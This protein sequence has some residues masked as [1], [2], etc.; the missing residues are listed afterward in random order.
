MRSLK[1]G[2]RT[3]TASI[4]LPLSNGLFMMTRNQSWSGGG[5]SLW[6][7]TYLAHVRRRDCLRL[8]VENE[9]FDLIADIVSVKHICAVGAAPLRNFW[10]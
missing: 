7:A 5:C 9:P 2:F 8:F 4:A 3:I 1:G 10:A 6:G